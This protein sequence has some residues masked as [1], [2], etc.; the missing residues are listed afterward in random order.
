MT[1]PMSV[2]T[3]H[4]GGGAALDQAAMAQVDNAID[5]LRDEYQP[6]INDLKQS[7]EL[8]RQHAEELRAK[9]ENLEARLN[10]NVV[11]TPGDEEA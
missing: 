7:L 5:Q 11:R 3:S 6:K 4:H 8:Q 9:K 2:N 10:E 1:G